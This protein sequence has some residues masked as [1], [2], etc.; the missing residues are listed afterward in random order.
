MLVVDSNLRIPLRE[1]SFQFARS[2]GPG[3]QNV[4]KLSTK[5]VLRWDVARSPSLPEPVRARFMARF[6]NRITEEGE[7]VL[8]SQ[9]HRERD[10]NREDCLEKLTAMLREVAQPPPPRKPTKVT[11]A[12]K[13]RRLVSKQQQ[14]D[15]KRRRRP[16]KPGDAE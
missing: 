5:V 16:V 15:K 1:F 12:A 7:L 9:R 13:E 3:G 10:R 2:S 8:S 4:N 14:A 6:Q 11:R